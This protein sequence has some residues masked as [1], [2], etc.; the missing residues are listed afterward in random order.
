MY[1]YHVAFSLHLVVHVPVDTVLPLSTLWLIL[2]VVASPFSVD[3]ATSQCVSYPLSNR[4][5]H[6]HELV[7]RVLLCVVL[8]GDSKCFC[9]FINY[10]FGYIFR[11][12][13]RDSLV[14]CTADSLRLTLLL[15]LLR[16]CLTFI[17]IN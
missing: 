14:S 15:R 13:Y 5:L 6:L 12:C 16:L 2:S 8:H 9:D 4:F 17:L 7:D 10:N 11:C 1:R 3:S